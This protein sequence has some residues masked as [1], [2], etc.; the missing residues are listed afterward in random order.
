MNDL[1]GV[2][3]RT[4]GTQAE[5]NVSVF[6]CHSF[7]SMSHRCKDNGTIVCIFKKREGIA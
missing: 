6:F 4:T 2:D 5:A 3:F 1:I 7:I